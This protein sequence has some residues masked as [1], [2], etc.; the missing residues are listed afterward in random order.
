MIKLYID[1]NIFIDVLQNRKNRSGKDIAGFAARLFADA[2]S[3]KYQIILSSWTLQQ[4]YLQNEDASMLFAMLKSKTIK[5]FYNEDDRK[6]AT[7]RSADNFDDALHIILA[8]KAKANFIITRN[9]SDFLVIGSNI[10][11]ALPENI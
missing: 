3:C 6:K 8:E 7:L 10:P 5:V 2:V 1:T 11:I 9:L 4:I